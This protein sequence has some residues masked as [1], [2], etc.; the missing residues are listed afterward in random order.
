MVYHIPELR[1]VFANSFVLGSHVAI[2]Y[3]FKWLHV[4]IVFERKMDVYFAGSD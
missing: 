1:I 2:I 3:Y 4:K